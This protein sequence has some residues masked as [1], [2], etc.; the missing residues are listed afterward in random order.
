ME[1]KDSRFDKAGVNMASK[2]HKNETK[3]RKGI[4]MWFIILILALDIL[5]IGGIIIGKVHIDFGIIITLFVFS[6]IGIWLLYK[7]NIKN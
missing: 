7:E 2:R 1:N 4:G 6:P 3:F 5:I